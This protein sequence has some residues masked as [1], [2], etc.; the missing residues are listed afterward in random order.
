VHCYRHGGNDFNLRAKLEDMI[1][2]EKKRAGKDHSRAD[3]PVKFSDASRLLNAAIQVMRTLGWAWRWAEWWV[4]Y[5]SS[6]E[7]LLE[8]GQKEHQM[9]KEELKIVDSTRESRCED[10]RR[11]RLAAFGAALRNR[12]YDTEDGFNS[13]ALDR[14]LQAVLSTDSL[15]GPLKQFEVDFF[16]EWLSLAYRSKSRLLYLGEHKNQVSDESEFIVHIAD[17]SPKYELGER[18]VPGTQEL[19]EGKVFEVGINE[20]DDFMQ[21]DLI[22]SPTSSSR[23]KSFASKNEKPQPSSVSTATRKVKRKWHASAD[24]DTVSVEKTAAVIAVAS[25][26]LTR[27]ERGRTPS[28]L[29]L[30]PPIPANDNIAT[31]PASGKR[32]RRPPREYDDTIPSSSYSGEERGRPPTVGTSGVAA[33]SDSGTAKP[34]YS[35]KRR[36]RPPKKRKLDL[37]VEAC[38]ESLHLRAGAES[39]QRSGPVA[40]AEE[41]HTHIEFFTKGTSSDMDEEA[42]ILAT[43]KVTKMGGAFDLDAG[44][45]SVARRTNVM[46]TVDAVEE[47]LIPSGMSRDLD[48][49]EKLPAIFGGRPL[50][51]TGDLAVSDAQD[52]SS[53]RDQKNNATPDLQSRSDMKREPLQRGLVPVEAVTSKARSRGHRAS[54]TLLKLDG[55]SEARADDLGPSPNTKWSRRRV[56]SRGIES[57][58]PEP[59]VQ[60]AVPNARQPDEIKSR[61]RNSTRPL[62]RRVPGNT[63]S[64]DGDGTNPLKSLKRAT[65]SPRVS[66]PEEGQDDALPIWELVA[67]RKSMS[68]PLQKADDLLDASNDTTRPIADVG[69][70]EKPEQSSQLQMPIAAAPNDDH[71]SPKVTTGT[72]PASTQGKSAE[73]GGKQEGPAINTH[74]REIDETVDAETEATPQQRGRR[75]GKK[76]AAVS[77]SKTKWRE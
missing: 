7:P 15:V 68:P 72:T 32:R 47:S 56:A 50:A 12:D 25:S 29:Q 11:C 52:E 20:T 21:R 77:L 8:P 6:W 75:R 16:V 46:E 19:S 74:S 76:Q 24:D 62:S 55:E 18:P 49:H 4:D 66:N 65:K 57:V 1:E 51:V 33:T 71:G 58:L 35:G 41:N 9:T 44:E 2:I 70:K 48:C 39:G 5:D 10:A 22:D 27:R 31:T 63:K 38:G 43:E 36:G 61:L 30:T 45:K 53:S 28:D 59:V 14:A 3:T 69:S 60:G 42:T 54:N 23:G 37:N 34:P 13:I 64:Y 26:D 40:T 73:T 67:K 17:K